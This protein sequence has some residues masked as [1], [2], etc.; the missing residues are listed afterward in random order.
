MP[1]FIFLFH[2]LTRRETLKNEKSRAPRQMKTK[3]EYLVCVNQGFSGGRVESGASRKRRSLDGYEMSR[4]EMAKPATLDWTFGGGL[5][6]DCWGL[7]G[8]KR[9]EVWRRMDDGW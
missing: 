2:R 8:R 1:F 9:E 3:R 7:D 5:M 4:A 6:L